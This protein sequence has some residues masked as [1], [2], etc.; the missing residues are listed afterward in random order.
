VATEILK[1]FQHNGRHTFYRGPLPSAV[2]PDISAAAHWP[3]I[4]HDNYWRWLLGDPCSIHL[5]NGLGAQREGESR[6]DAE[7]RRRRAKAKAQLN[8]EYYAAKNI[9]R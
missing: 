1:S 4:E 6:S 8:A 2:Y 5:H 3:L 9:R 7:D